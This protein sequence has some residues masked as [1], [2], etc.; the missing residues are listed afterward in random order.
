VKASDGSAALPVTRHQARRRQIPP[1]TT[2]QCEHREEVSDLLISETAFVAQLLRNRFPCLATTPFVTLSISAVPGDRLWWEGKERG[3][4]GR[5]GWRDRAGAPL[6][7][8]IQGSE[9]TISID[10]QR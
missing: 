4:P 3:A 6:P 10:P 8:F 9:L 2:F 5:S 1:L 7:L